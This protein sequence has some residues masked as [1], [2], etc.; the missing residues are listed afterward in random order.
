MVEILEFDQV[1]RL[2]FAGVLMFK[3][4]LTLRVE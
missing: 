3:T 2:H 1:K 4:Q